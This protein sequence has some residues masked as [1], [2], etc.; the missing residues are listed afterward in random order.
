LTGYAQLPYNTC[1][2]DIVLRKATHQPEPIAEEVAIAPQLETPLAAPL[3]VPIPKTSS[4]VKTERL[5]KVVEQLIDGS[6]RN[7]NRFFGVFQPKAKRVVVQGAY[8]EGL[9]APVSEEVRKQSRL[10]ALRQKRFHLPKPDGQAVRAKAAQHVAAQKL[11]FSKLRQ[12]LKTPLGKLTLIQGV[13]LAALF[14]FFAFHKP[15]TNN[16][17]RSAQQIVQTEIGLRKYLPQAGAYTPP[18]PVVESLADVSDKP[19]QQVWLTPWNVGEVTQHADSYFSISAF[20]LS[21]NSD[22]TTF[23]T[24]ADWSI[25]NDYIKQNRKDGQTYYLT[26]SGNPNYTY[27]ALTDPQKQ[28]AHIQNLLKIVQDNG[29]DGVDIDYE[30]LGSENSDLFNQFIKAVHTTFATAGKKVVVTVE[31]RLNNQ[32]PMDWYT[33]GQ[34][35]DQIRVMVYDYHAR[36]TGT[37]GPVSPIGWLQEIMDYATKIIPAEKLVIGLANYGYDWTQ[38]TGDDT[39]WQGVGIGYDQ[40]MALAQEKGQSVQRATGID[41]RGYDIGSVPTF[42]YTDDQGRQHSVW[43]EDQNSIDPKVRLVSQYHTAGVIFWSVGLGDTNPS[44]TPAGQ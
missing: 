16:S 34:E 27:I 40:A 13:A 20:W 28:A 14:G 21:V 1:M 19:A 38:P 22:G 15:T 39:Q 43:F 26:V 11:S 32:V 37:P 18:K 29:F 2:Q 42:T 33:L 8:I 44:D 5:R 41:D 23:Q 25:W 31:A 3:P 17:P 10:R 30:G 35:A 36:L 9:S 7:L 4:S 6:S 12:D 24:K